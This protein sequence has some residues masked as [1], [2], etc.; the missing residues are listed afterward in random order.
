MVMSENKTT[1]AAGISWPSLKKDNLPFGYLL[2]QLFLRE[3]RVRYLSLKL[4]FAWAIFSGLVQALTIWLLFRAVLGAANANRSFA[5]DLMIG[6]LAWNFFRR[7][8]S[9]SSVLF[10][11][12]EH[13]L[14]LAKFR[15]MVLP[16]SLILTDLTHFLGT[17]ILMMPLFF[18]F[19]GSLGWGVFWLIFPVMLLGLLMTGLVL[20]LG[21]LGVYYKDAKY[22]VDAGLQ[23]FFWVTPVMYN[24]DNLNVSEQVAWLLRLNPLTGLFEAMRD[25]VASGTLSHPVSF[26]VAAVLSLLIF[27]LGT[28]IY[29]RKG[30]LMIDYL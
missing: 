6:F 23:F 3:M 1:P 12:N 26:M 15:R 7:T 9:L 10:Q 14:R 21:V 13:I 25:I 30:A 22:A 18:W 28:W 5:V 16:I 20:A 8:I 19:G 24:I 17:L 4:G 2:W 29:K 27:A 11:S